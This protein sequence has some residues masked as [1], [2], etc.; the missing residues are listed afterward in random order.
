M[1]RIPT[2]LDRVHGLDSI[3]FVC[4]LWVFFSHGAA[5]A[6]PD[7]F[8]QA[9]P[10]NIALTAVWAHIWSGQAAV[11][12]FFVISGFCIHFPFAHSDRQPRLSEFYARRFLRLLVPLAAVIP[13][14]RL[15]SVPLVLYHNSILW[16]LLA[17]LIYYLWYPLLRKLQLWRVSWNGIFLVSFVAALALAATNPTAGSFG[18]SLTWLLRLP[19][20]VL[21]CL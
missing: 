20:W 14:S 1:E 11:M 16:S 17:E 19:C 2:T 15:L 4:A 12:I 7:L 10:T 9:S 3:R 5:P 18:P 8:P 6:I 21:G 13:L